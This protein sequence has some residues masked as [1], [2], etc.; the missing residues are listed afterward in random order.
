MMSQRNPAALQLPRIFSQ[1]RVSQNSPRHFERLAGFLSARL[2]RA[3]TR[4]ERQAKRGSGF[5]DQKFVR[6]TTLPAKL[7]VEMSHNQFPAILISELIQ[8]MEQHHRIQ[9]PRNRHN[10]GL[11]TRQKLLCANGLFD[12]GQKVGHGNSLVYRK[13][14]ARRLARVVAVPT[15][16]AARD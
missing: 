8:Q 6:I 14:S 1:K 3:S 16:Q 15:W 13:V 12:M 2:Y 10:D 9:P 5:A 7:M 11:S 4:D